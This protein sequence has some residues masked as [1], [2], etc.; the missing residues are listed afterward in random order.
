LKESRIGTNFAQV[1]S[2][3]SDVELEREV[4]EGTIFDSDA[5]FA[6][7][8]RRFSERGDKLREAVTD[9]FKKEVA[10]GVFALE[11]KLG[12]EALQK[13]KSFEE[14]LRLQFTR[15]GFSI[16]C[17]QFES[18]DLDLVR[19]ILAGGVVGYSSEGIEYLKKC[20][21]WEDIRL[22]LSAVE[23]PDYAD[24]LLRSGNDA[25]YGIAA[26]ATYAMGR[27][28]FGELI[29]LEM[30]T[31][32]LLHIIVNA[33]DKAFR[34]LADSQILN[35]LFSKDDDVRKA[36]S[37]KCIRSL[38]KGRM[39][40]LFDAYLSADEYRFYNVIF[41]LDMGLSISRER[42]TRAAER[43]IESTWRSKSVAS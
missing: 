12:A 26:R 9:Q 13:V 19:K 25:K 24:S 29:E 43:V 40:R 35:L 42:A 34:S 39:A 15:Q 17:R 37:L 10:D 7:D 22:I 41:W 20:G 16:I 23:K 8:E 32:V 14:H 5:R 4:A 6:L 21:E 30:P 1:R 2:L 3:R 27:S 11:A 36:A 38:A 28:R 18:R 33:S 31:R